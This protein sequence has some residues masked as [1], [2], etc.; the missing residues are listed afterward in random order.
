[1]IDRQ[2]K[3]KK[4]FSGHSILVST[5]SGAVHLFMIWIHIYIIIYYHISVFV[6]YCI[7]KSIKWFFLIFTQICKGFLGMESKFFCGCGPQRFSSS[8]PLGNGVVSA[9][10]SSDMSKVVT[11]AS[12]GAAKVW[13][14]ETG[15]SWQCIWHSF[16]MCIL[17]KFLL[18]Q[19]F[20]EL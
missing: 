13:N 20:K 6:Y 12:D 4:T 2:R 5:R 7:F 15:A 18:M 16:F 3:C 10:F 19:F 14:A 11:A 8:F 1:M 17:P 9:E